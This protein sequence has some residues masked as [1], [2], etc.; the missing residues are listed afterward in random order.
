VLLLLAQFIGVIG[1]SIFAFGFVALSAN[2]F[3]GAYFFLP[4]I[5][6]KI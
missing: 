1:G 6:N 4:S 3:L 2:F 5:L